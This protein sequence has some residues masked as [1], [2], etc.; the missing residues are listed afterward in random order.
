VSA[1]KRNIQNGEVDHLYPLCAGGS[2]D[3]SNLWYQPAMNKWNGKNFG[4][5]EKDELEAYICRQIVAGDLEPRE[6]FDK[7]TTDWVAY[8]LEL[9]LD[10]SSD[11]QEEDIN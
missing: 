11:G 7:I 10:K 6:A 5:H 2:N 4:F 9:H 1:D 3:I 8:Y